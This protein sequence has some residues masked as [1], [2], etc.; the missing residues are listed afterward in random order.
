MMDSLKGRCDLCGVEGEVK[1]VRAPLCV[2]RV[3]L[4]E[5]C[6]RRLENNG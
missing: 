6:L 3:Y 1:E 2:A 4:C 5:K